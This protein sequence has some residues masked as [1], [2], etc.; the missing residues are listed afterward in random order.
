MFEDDNF[1]EDDKK[2]L[3]ELL[4]AIQKNPKDPQAFSALGRY[5]NN[6]GEYQQ[7]IQYLGSHLEEWSEDYGFLDTLAFAYR[8]LQDY[9]QALKIYQL[10]DKKYP[11]ENWVM[12]NLAWC[13]AG[14]GRYEEAIDYHLR[15][16]RTEPYV[17]SITGF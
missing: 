8:E 10:I 11:N 17:P 15:V 16:H 1:D 12:K 9:P 14:L 7:T 4:E 13:L 3:E 5:F 2:S 6:K